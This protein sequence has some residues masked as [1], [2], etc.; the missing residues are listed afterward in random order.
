MKTGLSRVQEHIYSAALFSLLLTIAFAWPLFGTDH[1]AGEVVDSR[2]NLYVLE[3]TYQWL[4]GH[5]VSLISPPIFYP[6]PFVLFFSDT[7][8][9]SSFIYALFRLVGSSEYCA[10]NLWFLSGHFLSFLTCYYALARWNFG[11]LAAGIGACVFAFGLPSIAQMGHPQL[12]HRFCIPLAIY[13]LERFCR[14]RDPVAAMAALCFLCWQLL[15]SAYLG[16]FLALLMGVF[17]MFCLVLDRVSPLKSLHELYGNAWAFAQRSTIAFVA[18]LILTLA[19]VAATVATFGGHAM[20]ARL[21][22]FSRSWNEILPL[23]PRPTS[24]LIADHLPYWSRLWFLQRPLQI[25]WEH[26]MFFGVGASLLLLVGCVA[27]LRK[28]QPRPVGHVTLI[29]LLSLLTLV[30]LVTTV[31]GHTLYWLVYLIPGVD[32]LRAVSRIILILA[33]P[34]G[35]LCAA[36][37]MCLRQR[38]GRLGQVIGLLLACLILWEVHAAG[39]LTYDGRADE[40]RIA[41]LANSAREGAS[42]TEQPILHVISHPLTRQFLA[43]VDAMLASQRL[44]WPTVDG[45]SGFDLIGPE[46]TCAT[47][48]SFYSD[49]QNWLADPGR[50]AQATRLKFET[51][52][53]LKRTVVVGRPKCS[54]VAYAGAT[55]TGGDPPPASA[56]GQFELE[57]AGLEI[58]P[59]VRALVRIRNRSSAY[60]HARSRDPMRLSWQY[61]KDGRVEGPEWATRTAINGDIP[62]GGE[63]IDAIETP[64]PARAGTYRLQVSMVVEGRFWFHNQGMKVLTFNEPIVVR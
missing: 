26:N 35:I 53:L 31:K 14:L 34:V 54:A 27:A 7:H 33:F 17:A 20:V 55:V 38:L 3:H 46:L 28:D 40:V 52:D 58:G 56:A 11:P 42:S 37:L 5:P 25:R 61:V 23:L 22:G 15:I 1:I 64:L 45:Y 50:S 24:Y 57:A 62:P 16:I 48:A 63:Q 41:A 19:L 21:Y 32:A 4:T 47:P 12:V 9:G 29:A 6:Y 39:Q 59:E 60:V 51:L 43:H 49:F 2:Y 18:M 8:F 44:G 30:A 10:F 13:F 36:G